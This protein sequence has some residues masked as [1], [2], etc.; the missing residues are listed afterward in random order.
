MNVTPDGELDVR[1]V[2]NADLY[3]PR[4]AA[5]IA[6]ALNAALDAFATTPDAAVSTVES[7]PAAEMDRLLVPATR[8][9]V[10]RRS[11]SPRQRH[12]GRPYRF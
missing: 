10:R 11:R 12:S 2:A 7:L 6:D 8:K 3:E 5:L 1:I 4:T 9:P